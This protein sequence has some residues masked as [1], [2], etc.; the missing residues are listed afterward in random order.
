[1]RAQAY[2]DYIDALPIAPLPEAFGL[3]DN[4]DITKDMNSTGQ[5]LASLLAASG[6]AGGGSGASAASAADKRVASVVSECMARLPPDFDL[7]EVQRR[8]PVQY[9]QSLNTTLVQEMARY[10]RLLGVIRGSLGNMALALKGQLVMSGELEAAF[11][12]LAVNQV[13]GWLRGALLSEP[14]VWARPAG[15]LW[16]RVAP[17]HVRWA[18]PA[19]CSCRCALSTHCCLLLCSMPLV[20]A[21]LPAC[22][23]AGARAVAGGVLPLAA[24]AGLLPARPVR[25][26]GHAGRVGRPRPA[27]VLLAARLLLCPVVPHGCAAE[28]RTQV[29]AMRRSA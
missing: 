8:Y 5:V 23:P 6:G 22:I 3:H 21:C 11:S 14:A 25:P 20:L 29:G 17:E 7:E 19:S 27:A 24:A 1:L 13:R 15:A 16:R 4:A 9:G 2:L 12:S 28:L 18:R 26:A 10:N